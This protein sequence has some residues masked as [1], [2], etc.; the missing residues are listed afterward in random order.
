VTNGQFRAFAEAT[1]Y[2]TEAQRDVEGGFGI[3]F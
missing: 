3:D 2:E 1:A